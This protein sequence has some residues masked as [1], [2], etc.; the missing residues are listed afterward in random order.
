MTTLV[1]VWSGPRNV[2][3]ALMYA[4]RQ[5]GDTSVVD[6]PLYAAWLARNPDAAHPGR[7]AVLESQ[8]TDPMAVVRRLLLGP[9]S[10]DVVMAKQMAAHLSVFEQLDWLDA[11][12]N[13]ILVRA[14]EPVV[15]SYTAQVST[16]SVEALGYTAQAELL[17]RMEDRGEV[18]VLESSRL[19]ADPAGVLTRLCERLGLPFDEAMLSWPAGPKPEDGV[20]AEHW[21]ATTHA[22]NGFAVP[23]PRPDPVLPPAFAAV[24]AAARPVYERLAAVAL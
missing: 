20:W 5:R 15:A 17:H 4:F 12:R 18:L 23:T 10:T 9:W 16:P 3:T 19:L 7:D 6:E 2:S 1:N 14:P 8:P 22:S 13:V 11:A 24:A 21:Y